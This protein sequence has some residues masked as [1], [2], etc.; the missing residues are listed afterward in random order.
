MAESTK[1]APDPR[2]LSVKQIL[3]EQAQLLGL[4]RDR[5]QRELEAVTVR[6]DDA[7]AAIE[8]IEQHRRTLP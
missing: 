3:M 1:P 4:E 6:L 2:P 8:G 5:L 7:Y